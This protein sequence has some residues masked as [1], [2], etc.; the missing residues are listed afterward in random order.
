MRGFAPW[1]RKAA[2]MAS[3]MVRPSSTRAGERRTIADSISL[4]MTVTVGAITIVGGLLFAAG[5]LLGS[6][7]EFSER[8]IDPDRMAVDTQFGDGMMVIDTE[9]AIAFTVLFVLGVIVAVAAAG[10]YYSRKEVAPL[11]RA[12][13]LQRNFVADAS[14]ELKTPLAVISTRIDLIDFR[15][16]HGQNIDEPL[17][18]LRDDVDRMNAIVTDLLTAARG[19]T[20][21]EPVRIADAVARSVDAVA[22]LAERQ[23]VTIVRHDDASDSRLVVDGNLTGISRCLVAVLDN[24]ITHSPRGQ[25]VSVRIGFGHHDDVAIRIIDHGP[26]IGE[27]PERLFQRFARSDDGTTHQ[28][29]GLGLALARDVANRYHGSIIVEESSPNG[30]T[31]L[32]RFPLAE[33]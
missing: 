32:V 22:P 29:Y 11:E 16:A 31:M 28:G 13:R 24:A 12:L 10:W 19:A 1:F 4:R 3:S 15:L 33:Q 17:R 8:G 6:R 7:H 20:H 27:D 5:V 30:T 26:G 23:G 18:D 25:Q 9:K 21:T 2:D 14:H